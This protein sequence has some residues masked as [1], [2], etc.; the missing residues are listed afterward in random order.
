MLLK[1]LRQRASSVLVP[2]HIKAEA[3]VKLRRARKIS[4]QN[5]KVK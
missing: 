4:R 3:K 2:A 1:T 5:R